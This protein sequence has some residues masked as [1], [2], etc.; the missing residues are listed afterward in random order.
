M[1]GQKH[2]GASETFGMNRYAKRVDRLSDRAWL[3]R[4]L[5]VGTTTANIAATLDVTPRAV[6]YALRRH[7]LAPLARSQK[8]D[9]EA[10][11]AAYENGASL[12]RSAT[13]GGLADPLTARRRIDEAG[14]RVRPRSP[15]PPRGSKYPQL[16]DRIWL[17]GQVAAGA[18]AVEIA[19]AIGCDRRMVYDSLIR[20]DL[21]VPTRPPVGDTTAIIEAY[22]AGA[23]LVDAA[24]AGGVSVDTARRRL[25][26]A[27]VRIRSVPRLRPRQK[28]RLDNA[29]WLQAQRALGR[30]LKEIAQELDV[31][32][33]TVG[34]A[35]SRHGIS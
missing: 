23:N 6:R 14:I 11:I 13:A 28:R 22:Q 21:R 10:L 16:S 34:R 33:T 26:K 8:G 2:K 15:S 27:G 12:R 3:A 19:A 5:D 35:L 20:Y 24:K 29:R 7:G 17:A 4:Q 9:T 18:T 31:G 30:S 32:V 1:A 25:Q